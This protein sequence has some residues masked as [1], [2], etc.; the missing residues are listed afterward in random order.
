[1]KASKSGFLPFEEEI[2]FRRLMFWGVVGIWI[3]KSKSVARAFGEPGGND[4]QYA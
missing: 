2:F 4:S 3:L 1:V